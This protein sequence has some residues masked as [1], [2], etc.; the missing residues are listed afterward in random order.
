MF[1]YDLPPRIKAID[2]TWVYK[3]KCKP[4]GSIDFSKAR[5]VEKGKKHIINFYG[6]INS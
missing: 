5:F 2:I 4:N 3:L 6:T 1:N